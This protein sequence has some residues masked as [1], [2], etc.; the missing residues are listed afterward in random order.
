MEIL[1]TREFLV[2]EGT[3]Y[4]QYVKVKRNDMCN[5][6]EYLYTLD[7]LKVFSDW[8]I[9]ATSSASACCVLTGRTKV[10]AVPTPDTSFF[11]KGCREEEG[12]AGWCGAKGVELGR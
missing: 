7:Y 10:L 8:V 2:C 12:G 4:E 1:A 11:I 9:S 5:V 3:E 6:S